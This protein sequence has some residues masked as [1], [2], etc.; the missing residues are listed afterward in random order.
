MAMKKCPVCGVSVKVENLE[1]HVREQHP[2][3]RLD[4]NELLTEAE[5]HEV[6]TAASR[7]AL[8]GR[9]RMT[10]R[11]KL[12]LV[13]VALALVVIVAAIAFRPN[14]GLQPGQIA[15]DFTEPTS[16]GGSVHLYALRGQPLLLEFMDIDCPH[17][18]NEAGN[19]LRFLYQNYSGRVTFLSA[20]TNSVPPTDDASRINTF[21][22]Q[23]GTPWTY[24]L[25]DPIIVQTYG[26]QATP[27]MYVLD[28]NSV[29][30]RS[31]VGETNYTNL[32]GALDLALQV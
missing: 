10:G 13:V 17:C 9:P 24:A 23:T 4:P 18:I 3:T 28:R 8:A 12:I 19:V 15:P 26:V 31:F 5:R 20:D 29:V 27:T 1:R 7:A 21:R 2:K 6:S 30:V 16:D 25:Y 14:T 22:N 11:G 32:A